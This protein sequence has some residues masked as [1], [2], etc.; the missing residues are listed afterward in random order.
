MTCE[1][2]PPYSNVASCSPALCDRT[3]TLT[4]EVSRCRKTPARGTLAA[5][6]VPG[7]TVPNSACNEVNLNENNTCTLGPHSTFALLGVSN[8]RTYNVRTRQSR[9]CVCAVCMR[10]WC[11]M[12]TSVCP[13]HPTPPPRQISPSGLVTR[14]TWSERRTSIP[15]ALVLSP[16]PGTVA[17]AQPC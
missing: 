12:I 9:K 14:R 16:C 1:L 15:E 11:G 17:P 8:V 10:T 4:G 2:C 3:G 5:M 7:R 13:C 6:A